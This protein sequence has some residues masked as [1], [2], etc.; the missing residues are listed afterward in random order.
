MTVCVEISDRYC[1]A[2]ADRNKIDLV[3]V[4]LFFYLLNKI[5]KHRRRFVRLAE[6]VVRKKVELIFSDFFA[7]PL[8]RHH[9]VYVIP[10]VLGAVCNALRIVNDTDRIFHCAVVV[11][12]YRIDNFR[13]D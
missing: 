2:H 11:C 9:T 1:A 10:L 3:A 7:E 12:G 4:M 5:V 6:G 13:H 8:H